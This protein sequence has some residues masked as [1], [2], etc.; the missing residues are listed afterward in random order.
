LLI[1]EIDPATLEDPE[2]G[3]IAGNILN[4]AFPQQAYDIF[5]LDLFERHMR[6]KAPGRRCRG[7][8]SLA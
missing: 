6:A 8:F 3:E 7:R 5:K 4:A 1:E 2:F